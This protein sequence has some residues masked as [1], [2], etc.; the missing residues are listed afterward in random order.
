MPTL[1]Q[2]GPGQSGMI[3]SVANQFGAVKRRLVDMGLTPGTVVTVRKIAPLGDPIEVTLR[4]YEL[5]LRRDDA[6]QIEIGE[7]PRRVRRVSYAGTPRRE[8]DDETLRR[9]R[10][11]TRCALSPTTC[12]RASMTI[13][14]KAPC[15][16]SGRRS[17]R[18]SAARSA[19]SGRS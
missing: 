15:R 4:G 13:L 3:V 2:L 9:M 6:E 11:G 19:I 14:V 12:S 1:R 10:M 18:C 16:A 7:Q 17:M 8:L 5:S